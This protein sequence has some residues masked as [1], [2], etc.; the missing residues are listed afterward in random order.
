VNAAPGP[1]DHPDPARVGRPGPFLAPELVPAERHRRAARLLLIDGE[2]RLLVEHVRVAADPGQGSWWE[3]PGGGLEAGETT[4]EAARREL[5]EETGYVDIEIGPVVAT[6][7]VRYRSTRVVEQHETIHVARLRSHRRAATKLDTAE[8]TGLLEVAWVTLEELD[9]GRRVEPSELVSLARHVLSGMSF[10]RRLADADDLGWS[11]AAPRP[12]RLADGARAHVLTDRVVRDAAPWT[13][14]V[15][16][17]LGHCREVGITDVPAPLGIDA[18]GREAVT[19]V[20]GEV[21]GEGTHGPFPAGLRAT[22]GL[23]AMGELLAR[24]RRAS[25]GFDPPSDAVWRGGPQPIASG[26]VI[27]HGDVGHTNLVWQ[28]DGTPA[29]IDWEFAHPGPPLR[30]LAEAAC[31]LVPLVEFDHERRGFDR[32]PDRRARLHALV[33]AGDTDVDGL[34]HAI[35]AYLAAETARVEQLGALGVPP[36]SAFLANGQPAGFARVREYLATH[37]LRT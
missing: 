11:D 36:W 31:W 33:A 32:E 13:P 15:H 25:V 24:L 10:P 9:D 5:T 26:Q 18:N 4:E 6:R 35:E 22:E 20:P 17:W 30:D 1:R 7:R 23:A 21:T 19:L 14:A 37:D 2:D 27:C 16:A 34:F 29:L 8:A 3:A 28:P 12:G